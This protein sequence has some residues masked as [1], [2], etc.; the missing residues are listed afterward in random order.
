M[1]VETL[2]VERQLLCSKAI[3]ARCGRQDGVCVVGN[4]F[5]WWQDIKA[6]E[7][8]IWESQNNWCFDRVRK[9]VGS[10]SKTIIWLNKWIVDDTLK[11]RCMRLYS[12][13]T[14]EDA[15]VNEVCNFV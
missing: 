7:K 3:M 4:E 13:A 1:G 9:V 6:I 5:S 14:N 2:K 8:G 11:D 15:K 12:I 10:G